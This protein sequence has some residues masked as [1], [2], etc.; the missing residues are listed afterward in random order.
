[1]SW[2]DV[3]R[4]HKSKEDHDRDIEVIN[5]LQG[6]SDRVIDRAAEL[7]GVSPSELGG[8]RRLTNA[9]EKYERRLRG[10]RP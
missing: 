4:R 8:R 7:I 3:L 5:T 6:D 2:F 9:A 10:N 1:M